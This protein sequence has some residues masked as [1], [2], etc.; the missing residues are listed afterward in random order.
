MFNN[1]FYEIKRREEMEKQNYI[2]FLLTNPEKESII[3]RALLDS[4]L[5]SATKNKKYTCKIVKCGNYLQ[6]YNYK[7]YKLK[8]VGEYEKDT[9]FD[10]ENIHI[11]KQSC[12]RLLQTIELKNINRTK[13]Q[14]QRLA[15]ANIEKFKT[16]I[17]LTFSENIKDIDL[18][19]KKFH[20]FVTMVRRIEKEFAYICVPE[21]QK[22]GAVHYHLMTNLDIKQ[23]SLIIIPQKDG[24]RNC[25]DVKYWNNGFSSVEAITS[26]K[27]VSYL[28]KYM[29]KDIDNRLF[30]KKR[31]FYS[32]NLVK[33]EEAYLD[34]S[35]VYDFRIL[36]NLMNDM[37]ISHKSFY[38]DVFGE[39]IEFVEY[40]KK[41]VT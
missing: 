3:A 25:F 9:L 5:I 38:N 26:D 30:S 1:K 29:T 12:K 18:C 34:L 24:R 23:N 27:V 2:D 31:Y 20:S 36:I 41:A 11:N 33:P 10:Y 14:L 19:N 16:F 35:N 40:K 32:Q 6:V 7:N 37:E 17:T 39:T 4:S 13:F 15:K 21:F 8:G 28:S 22:R